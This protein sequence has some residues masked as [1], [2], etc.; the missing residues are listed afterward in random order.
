[1]SRIKVRA[2][3]TGYYGNERRY[4]GNIFHVFENKFSK[5]WMEKVEESDS[6]YKNRQ[7]EL[8]K[9]DKTS[10]LE[11]GDR[12]GIEEDLDSMKKNELQESILNVEFG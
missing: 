4:E 12:L 10:L 11:I 3:Q 7:K 5:I 8:A 6:A 2:T 9:A 1:M